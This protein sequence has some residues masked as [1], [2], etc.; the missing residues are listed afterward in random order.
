M[1]VPGSL[2]ASVFVTCSSLI[3]TAQ[4]QQ[5]LEYI[6]KEFDALKATLQ[7]DYD[8]FLGVQTK[9]RA[10]VKDLKDEVGTAERKVHTLETQLEDS[11]VEAAEWKQKYEKL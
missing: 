2:Y 9:H 5:R 8:N 4:F 11:H 10:V 7:A 1:T 3:N 6:R